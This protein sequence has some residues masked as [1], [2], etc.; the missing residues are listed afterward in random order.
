[1]DPN[2]SE[3]IHDKHKR[4]ER[5]SAVITDL[6]ENTMVWFGLIGST[7]RQCTKKD[8]HEVGIL[9]KYK[10]KYNR[11]RQQRSKWEIDVSTKTITQIEIH[12][13]NN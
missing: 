8:D 2:S 1:M 12:K 11:Q 7:T 6:D 4:A 3:R 9:Y 13:Y 10:Y 5:V